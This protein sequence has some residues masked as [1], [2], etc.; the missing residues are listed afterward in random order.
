ML[1]WHARTLYVPYPSTG[2]VVLSLRVCVGIVIDATARFSAPA[3]APRRSSFFES[4]LIEM[5]EGKWRSRR[6][7]LR[8]AALWQ[9]VTSD[10]TR[11]ALKASAQ[12]QTAESRMRA[13]AFTKRDPTT[14]APPLDPQL[15]CL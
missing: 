14:L 7:P 11:S 2:C 4:M 6:A 5:R 1:V 3:H 10:G 9:T 8:K 12:P 15:T 13:A